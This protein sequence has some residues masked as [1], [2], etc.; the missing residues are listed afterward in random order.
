MGVPQGSI[1]GPLLFTLFVN[2]LTVVQSCKVMLYADDTTIYHS[3]QDSQQLQ[4]TLVNDLLSIANWL[5]TNHLQM[6]VTKSKTAVVSK[7]K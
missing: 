4:D 5:K 7:E 3:C 6:S 1:L 2:D